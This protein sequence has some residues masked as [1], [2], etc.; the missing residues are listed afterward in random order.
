M[1]GA[2]ISD[3]SGHGEKLSVLCVRPKRHRHIAA[4]AADDV[5]DVD[6]VVVVV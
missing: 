6:V 1:P 3:V 4:A 5:D 2:I